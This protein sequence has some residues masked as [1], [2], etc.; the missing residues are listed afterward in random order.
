MST[1]KIVLFFFSVNVLSW[2]LI[3]GLL[4]ATP[5]GC[6]LNITTY[7]EA[8]ILAITLMSTIGTGLNGDPCVL[9]APALHCISP[10]HSCGGRCVVLVGW[11]RNVVQL[12]K[13]R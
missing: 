7:D 13:R 5:D 9:V 3:A 6:D 10:D 2:L 11:M 8:L 4:M 1:W 12:H